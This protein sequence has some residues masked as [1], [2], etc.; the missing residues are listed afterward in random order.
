GLLVWSAEFAEQVLEAYRSL[1]RS[2]P[3]ELTAAAMIRLAPPAPFVPAEAHFKPIIGVLVCHSGED[4]EA[5]L[6]PLRALP[7][8]LIDQVG[9]HPYAAQQSMFDNLDPSGFAQY[10]KT[11]FLADLSPAY[12][13]VWRR[14][15]LA[16]ASPMSY[17]VIFHIEG[18]NNERGV[19]DGA[20]G[21]RDAR[22][23]S[24]FSGVWPPREDGRAIIAAVREGWEQ[25]R[26]FS[27]GGNYVNF[28]LAE[29][30]DDR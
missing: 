7:P 20:V 13:D 12:L 2:A 8:P 10:W 17:S 27:T 29:D 22:F 19:D 23:V 14:A 18:A 24:G 6:A 26:P 16:V 1:T 9:E 21:N 28:Q 15:A 30:A 5:D 11:E 25:I 4:P 3:R